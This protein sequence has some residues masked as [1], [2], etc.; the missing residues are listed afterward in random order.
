MNKYKWNRN[1]FQS[2]S[3]AR[4]TAVACI[5]TRFWFKMAIS[6]KSSKYW[7]VKI[8]RW[9]GVNF[10]YNALVKHW[11]KNE[12]VLPILLTRKQLPNGGCPPGIPVLGVMAERRV[13]C[14]GP[15]LHFWTGILG[16]FG[17][18]LSQFFDGF[19]GKTLQLHTVCEFFCRFG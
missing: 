3:D 7:R 1:H 19:M 2:F 4:K 11:Q 5:A 18:D 16:R 15:P 12:W 9:V 13:F 17:N 8:G 10:P 6:Y 14:P